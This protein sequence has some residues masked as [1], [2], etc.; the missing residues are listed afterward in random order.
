[1]QN[2]IILKYIYIYFKICLK[3]YIFKYILKSNKYFLLYNKYCM[4]ILI[5]YYLINI[6]R[7]TGKTNFK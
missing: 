6:A 3:Y 5:L 1:M 7:L 4:E 2:N